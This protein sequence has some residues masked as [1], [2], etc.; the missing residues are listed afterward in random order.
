MDR[1]DLETIA[2]AR[3]IKKAAIGDL[4]LAFVDDGKQSLGAFIDEWVKSRPHAREAEPGTGESTILH[5]LSEQASLVRKVGEVEARAQIEALGG[6]LGS[7][8]KA[9]A[10]DAG[11]DPKGSSNPWSPAYRK[12]DK[13]QR[14]IG[15]IRALG[16]AKCVELARAQNRTI[17]DTP[18]RGGK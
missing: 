14:Q 9:P 6:T 4:E 10:A 11:V 15:L 8:T 13:Q 3:G 7:I 12:S 18:L 1:S 16:T 2:F 17:S 5:S